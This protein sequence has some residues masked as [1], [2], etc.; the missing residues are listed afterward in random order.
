MQYE[1]LKEGYTEGGGNNRKILI[2]LSHKS[3]S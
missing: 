1:S 2:R 3:L